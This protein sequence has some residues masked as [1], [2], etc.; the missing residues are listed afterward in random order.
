M[1]AKA[2][3]LVTVAGASAFFGHARAFR[4]NDAVSFSSH[5]QTSAPG[6]HARRRDAGLWLLVS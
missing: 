2:D 3:R 5:P 6:G 4:A 1:W